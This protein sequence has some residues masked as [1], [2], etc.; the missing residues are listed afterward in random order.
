MPERSPRA[1]AGKHRESD[2][3]LTPFSFD[4]GRSK[5]NSLLADIIGK[6]GG[7]I[8]FNTAIALIGLPTRNDSKIVRRQGNR[9]KRFII[10]GAPG[11]GKTAIIRQLELDGFS[12]VEEAATDVIAAAQA[13]G[14]AEPWLHPSFIDA[15][16]SLQRARQIR[17]SGQPDFV[18]F[19][20][21]SIFCTAA[22]AVYLGYPFSALLTSELERSQNE[23]IYQNRAFFIRNLGFI[24][25]TQARCISL[26]ETLR[27]ERIHEETYRRFGFEIVSIEPGSLLQ[28]V[29][30]IKAATV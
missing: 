14:T 16:A 6:V 27:F 17:A 9:M 3:H 2:P 13:R 20:D 10:T 25:H 22:L 15:V 24:A 7:R 19:H 26:E 4:G 23:G 28:R 8:C 21:R 30:M 5:R 18:Q 29:S 12:V 1:S 11:A